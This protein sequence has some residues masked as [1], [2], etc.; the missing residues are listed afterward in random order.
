MASLAVIQEMKE[1]TQALANAL[2]IGYQ[3]ESHQLTLTFIDTLN[4]LIEQENINDEHLNQL[5]T[6]MLDAQQ[7]DDRLF[8]ADIIQ[9]ELL[10]QLEKQLKQNI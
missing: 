7:R 8:Y 6:V 9:Y 2:R 10:P 4:H 1:L 3:A 5:F